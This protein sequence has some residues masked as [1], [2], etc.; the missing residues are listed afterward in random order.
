MKAIPVSAALEEECSTLAALKREGKAPGI[1]VSNSMSSNYSAPRRLLQRLLCSRG[2]RWC[3]A[4]S[5]TKSCYC[6]REGIGA[7]VYSPMVS[8]LLTGAMPCER[9]A[10]LPK[11]DR[12]RGHADFTEPNVSQYGA[13]RGHA[14]DSQPPHCETFGSVKSEIG[15]AH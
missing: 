13:G 5:K 6:L 4:R 3:S 2:I 12:R 15:R 9:A 10:S 11:D 8:G 14:G 7:I 1:G